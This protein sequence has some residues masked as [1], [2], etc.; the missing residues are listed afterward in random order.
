MKIKLPSIVPL[1]MCFGDPQDMIGHFL[2]PLLKP[3]LRSFEVKQK[4]P[5]WYPFSLLPQSTEYPLKKK[6]GNVTWPWKTVYAFLSPKLVCSLWYCLHHGFL[7]SIPSPQVL[8]SLLDIWIS[9]CCM[10]LSMTWASDCLYFLKTFCIEI[11]FVS[12]PS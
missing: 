10:A 8:V 6:S 1:C 9:F 2:G 3:L 7:L 12:S 5:K 4:P 11:S